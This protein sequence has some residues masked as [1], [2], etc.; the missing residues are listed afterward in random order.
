VLGAKDNQIAVLLN[1]RPG[2]AMAAMGKS[3]SDTEVAAVITYT[4]NAWSNKAAEGMVTPAEVKAARAWDA[5]KLTAL[6]AKP[7]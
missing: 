4:R 6:A 7:Q 1:G 3:M 5:A 2:T